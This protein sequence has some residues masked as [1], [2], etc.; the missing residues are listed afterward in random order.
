[1][2]HVTTPTG[3]AG[4]MH[5]HTHIF[6]GM[7][8]IGVTLMLFVPMPPGALNS[9]GAANLALAILLLIAVRATNQPGASYAF[10]AFYLTIV[11][12]RLALNVVSTRL[13]MASGSEIGGQAVEPS[14]LQHI[15][16]SV[17]PAVAAF[18]MPNHPLIE[19]ATYGILAA[20]LFMAVDSG[21]RSTA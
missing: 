10:P 1:M 16:A 5:R 6:V 2:A 12:M 8:A 14:R 13:I 3:F 15:D 11:T 20:C 17:I 9:L 18:V 21:R 4:W 7:S 19:I